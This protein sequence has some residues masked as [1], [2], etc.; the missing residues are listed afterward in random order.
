M[1]LFPPDGRSLSG[2]LRLRGH[3]LATRVSILVAERSATS[4]KR[5][6]VGCVV[7]RAGA[8]CER[9]T[10]SGIG[11]FTARGGK[12]CRDGTIAL[13]GATKIVERGDSLIFKLSKVFTCDDG[14]G[15]FTVQVPCVPS[16]STW[17]R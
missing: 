1:G 3:I 2:L 6:S 8:R 13:K 17:R 7:D 11:A 16:G 9:R 4:S 12:L 10:R 14:S 5:A 15:T